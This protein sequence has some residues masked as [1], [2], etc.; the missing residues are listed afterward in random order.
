MYERVLGSEGSCVLQEEEI[1]TGI[2]QRA[3][4]MMREEHIWTG[5][6]AGQASLSALLTQRPVE[7]NVCSGLTCGL[8]VSRL[9]HVHASNTI[10][11]SAH[12]LL[13]CP[14]QADEVSTH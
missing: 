3:G 2:R 7:R 4:G 8:A 12:L 10:S 1:I 13:Y 14:L 5:V 6:N 11:C 9:C